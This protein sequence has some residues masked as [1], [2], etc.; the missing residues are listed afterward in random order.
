MQNCDGISGEQGAPG[1]GPDKRKGD[2]QPDWKPLPSGSQ[3][4]PAINMLPRR[5]H[6]S[7]QLHHIP[8]GSSGASCGCEGVQ[9]P[10]NTHVG[11]SRE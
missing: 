3:D 10:A 5:P 9:K 4:G 7:L 6:H 2:A 11:I 8:E 1:Q